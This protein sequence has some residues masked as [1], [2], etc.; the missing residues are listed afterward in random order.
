MIRAVSLCATMLSLVLL[1]SACAEQWDAELARAVPNSGS[2]FSRALQG[3]YATLA[4][5]E[6]AEQDWTDAAYFVARARQA[7]TA[8]VPPPAAL[9]ERDLPADALD[10][11]A[12]ARQRLASILRRGGPDR[13]PD[14]AA[15]AQAMFECWMQEQEEN[16]QPADIAACRDSF[17]A[18]VTAAEDKLLPE[19][20]FVVLPN[21]DGT[22]GAITVKTDKGSFLLDK[23][24]AAAKVGAG[25][26]QALAVTADEVQQSFG[27]ALSARPIPP[28]RFVLY[29]VENSVTLTAESKSVYATVF[30]DIHRRPV[31][32][33]EVVAHTDR[34]G[35]VSY[36]HRL[37]LD[38]AQAIRAQLVG[39]GID[40][41]FISVAGRGE[42]DPLVATADG[43]PEP[44]NR[45]VEILVR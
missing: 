17:N 16:H 9:D 44:R 42:L 10:A 27:Q 6:R 32:E 37:S 13:A 31:A 3:E 2:S 29:F 24:L 36:N 8:E 45:R 33:V 25:D 22:A 20:F 41:G 11:L 38:R 28:S 7:A 19:T 1:V 18:A 43:V 12:A 40:G 23:P 5:T 4:A 39:D 30:R 35:S 14:E 26:A 21:D 34:L 15:R